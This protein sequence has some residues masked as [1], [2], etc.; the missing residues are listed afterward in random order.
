MSRLILFGIIVFAFCMIF[1]S[2]KN[3]V[4]LDASKLDTAYFTGKYKTNYLGK[5]EKI[6]LKGNG[7]YDYLNE[8]NSDTIIM[9]A[10]KWNF[11]SGKTCSILLADYPN[12]RSEKVFLDGGDKVNLS[13]NVNTHI[14]ENLGD[15]E[16]LVID[17]RGGELS[18]IFAKQ[19]KIRN[20]DYLLKVE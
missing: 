13:L 19:D 6:F 14:E 20:K 5:I 11:E 7:W 10:G 3:S 17:E 1:S 8:E 16:T 18:Y 12:I 4:K 9:N 15:L 2:C